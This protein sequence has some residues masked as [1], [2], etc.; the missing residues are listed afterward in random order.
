[1]EKRIDRLLLWAILIAFSFFLCLSFSDSVAFS[2]IFSGVLIS[3]LHH[4]IRKIPTSRCASRRKRLQKGEQ[5]LDA[6]FYRKTD[7]ESILRKILPENAK[8]L[9]RFPGN[10]LSREEV[11]NLWRAEQLPDDTLVLATSG[12]IPR[13]TED[14]AQSLQNPTVA[15]IGRQKI[16]RLLAKSEL[17]MPDFPKESIKGSVKERFVQ[18]LQKNRLGVVGSCLYSVV[19][20]T[21]YLLT[22]TL[23]YL[24]CALLLLLA[25]GATWY[26]KRPTR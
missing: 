13:L 11:M 12:S 8:V 20:M 26:I 22:G 14:F 18:T 19:L 25:G 9:Y 1:M 4:I 17:P 10:M 24:P 16:I 23:I 15:L 2:M 3:L 6:L 7:D 21:L 5:Y